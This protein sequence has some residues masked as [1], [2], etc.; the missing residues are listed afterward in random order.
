MGGTGVRHVDRYKTVLL[1][2]PQ[3][4]SSF[5]SAWIN[6]SK[7]SHASIFIAVANATTVTGSAV[8]LSQATD[9]NGTSSKA[10][11]FTAYWQDLDTGAS[12]AITQQVASSNTFTT[13]TTN[14]KNALYV[15][16]IHDT[17]FDLAN[18]FCTFQLALATATAAT[19]SAVAHLFPRNG[20]NFATMPSALT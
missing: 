6:M 13:L 15:V 18:L 1:C 14:S 17:D 3:T 8:T 10:L 19:L 9:I 7:F 11:A 12:D 16:E 20:G 2:A 5:T 4:P